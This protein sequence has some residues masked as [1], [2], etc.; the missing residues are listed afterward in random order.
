MTAPAAAAGTS[1]APGVPA[2]LGGRFWRL[3]ASSA[4]S[5]LA[6]GICRTALPLIAA[7][8]TR[9]PVAISGLAT[10][11]F[12]PWLLFGLLSGVLVDRVDRRRAM[13]AA[14]LARSAAT[15][16][17]AVLVATGVSGTG[18]LVALYAVGFA[19]G[20]AETVYD[21]AI[22]GLLPQVV[23]APRL[24][25]ANSLLTVEE[26]LGQAF[27]GGPVGSVLFAVAAALPLIVN[28]SGFAAAALLVLTL[29]GVF[30]PTRALAPVSVRRDAAD[31]VRWLAGHGL[32]RGLTAVSAG[33]AF[34]ESMATG[35]L[36]LYVLDVVHLPAGDF[37]YV[38]LAAGVGGVAGGLATPLLARRLG[39]GR[40][41]VA[42]A[43]VAAV[44][45]LLMGLTRSGY[46]AALLF[47]IASAG[48]M[49]WNVLTM[50]LRQTLI[51]PELFGRVQG[52]YRTVVWGGIPLGA[53]AGGLLA[54]LVG[55]QAVFVVVGALLLL[56]AG[57]LAAV[58]RRHPD[59]LD[60]AAGSVPAVLDDEVRAGLGAFPPEQVPD[61]V[62]GR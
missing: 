46:V 44:P 22:R 62:E 49:V 14:N 4:T 6:D 36:V 47:A 26:T 13:S 25:R 18:G 31:G 24:D 12:L 35:V 11:A 28:A 23:A 50:S 37:G 40:M 27:L 15:A 48:V 58:V 52:A 53:L 56:L 38:L 43:V 1:P 33:T 61:V 51:P 29:R 30:R 20:V 9:N 60:A 21:S 3:Y 17:L 41:L 34:A 57:G 7:G 19:L 54:D 39:R 42:G 55:V 8:Y 32:L 45:V 10:F 16:A 2:E 59:Q 5:N